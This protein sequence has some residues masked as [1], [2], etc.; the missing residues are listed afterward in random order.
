MKILCVSRLYCGDVVTTTTFVARRVHFWS[1][2]ED[3]QLHRLTSYIF[4][5]ADLCLVHQLNPADKEGAFLDDC[6]DAE[7]GGDP[8]TKA[9]G[10][11]WQELSSPYSER[12]WPICFGSKKAGHSSGSTADSEAWSLVG[13]QSATLKQNV[14]PILHQF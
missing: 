5:H 11:F 8:Y 14:I 4:H 7:L 13:A 9:S 6:P 10:G 2:N 12:K 1:L 3:R